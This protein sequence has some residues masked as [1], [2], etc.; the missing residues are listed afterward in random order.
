M[1]L[2]RSSGDSGSSGTLTA[3]DAD[4]VK[5]DDTAR[6]SYVRKVLDAESKLEELKVQL[7]ANNEETEKLEAR[8]KALS[9]GQGRTLDQRDPFDSPE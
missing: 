4:A 2:N 1:P 7:D 8:L 5:S 9:R 3:D 6:K